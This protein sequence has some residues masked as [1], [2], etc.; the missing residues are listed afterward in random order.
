MYFT[1]TTIE[2]LYNNDLLTRAALDPFLDRFKLLHA[3]FHE[4][5]ILTSSIIVELADMM[6]M[7]S[8]RL[9][10]PITDDEEFR[11]QVLE[12]FGV[13]LLACINLDANGNRFGRNSEEVKSH[14]EFYTLQILS[15]PEILQSIQN[16]DLQEVIYF[17]ISG[18]LS[19]YLVDDYLRA[20]GDRIKNLNNILYQRIVNNNFVD[21]IEEIHYIKFEEHRISFQYYQRYLNLD[22]YCQGEFWKWI[23]L[24]YFTKLKNPAYEFFKTY[25]DI[26]ID[27]GLPFNRV[28]KRRQAIEDESYNIKVSSA[29]SGRSYIINEE[30][31]DR[32]LEL[33]SYNKRIYAPANPDNPTVDNHHLFFPRSSYL[34][35]K[36][37]REFINNKMNRVD[38]IKYQHRNMNQFFDTEQMKNYKPPLV[39]R[40]LVALIDRFRESYSSQYKDFVGLQIAILR[41]AREFQNERVGLLALDVYDLLR[42]QARFVTPRTVKP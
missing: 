10:Y 1:T 23:S 30:L 29:T 36:V 38:M 13:V 40:E 35:D 8:K 3:N 7:A 32:E 2:E 9:N 37:L 5:S 21:K 26:V 11:S 22:E 24:K 17:C 4:S 15:S 31:K 16:R 6:K 33:R 14:L 42:L 39:T 19:E 28:I 18:R 34:Q 12:N 25:Q 27:S 20:F 41:I